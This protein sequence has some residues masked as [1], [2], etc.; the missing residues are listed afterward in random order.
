MF[1]QLNIKIKAIN[2]WAM[3]G[4]KNIKTQLLVALMAANAWSEKQRAG[5]SGI[6]KHF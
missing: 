1:G 6:F 2:I 3:L 4:Q 5:I